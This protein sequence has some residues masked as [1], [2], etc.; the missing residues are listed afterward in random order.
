MKLKG[1]IPFLEKIEQRKEEARRSIIVQVQ[2][3][4]SYKEL[5][6]YCSSVGTVNK[7]FH[8]TTGIEPMVRNNKN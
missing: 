1:Y 5:Y 8:Y 3:E 7:M 4:Q 6:T 2:S